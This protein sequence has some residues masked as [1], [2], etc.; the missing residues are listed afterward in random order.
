MIF[1]SKI[2]RN[3]LV[4]IPKEAYTSASKGTVFLISNVVY[5]PETRSCTSDKRVIGKAVSKLQM[6]PNSYYREHYPEEFNKYSPDHEQNITPYISYGLYAATLGIVVRNGLYPVM[7]E[8]FGPE[9]S[10]AM[11]DYA[12]YSILTQSNVTRDFQITMKQ[13]M[14]FSEKPHDDTWY[15]Q[16]FKT[17]VTDSQIELFRRKWAQKCI[18]CGLTD[19]WIAADGSNDTCDSESNILAENGHAKPGNKGDLVGFTWIV[20]AADGT[21]VTWDVYRGGRVDCKEISAMV[22]FLKWYS[23]TSKGIILDRGFCNESSLNYLCSNGLNYVVMLR[24]RI[25]GYTNTLEKNRELI[26]NNVAY[27]LDKQG[28]YGYTELAERKLFNSRNSPKGYV[29]LFYDDTNGS[30][31]RTSL[32]WNVK[33]AVKEAN[34]KQQK[35]SAQQESEA[36]NQEKAD[37]SGVQM[38]TKYESYILRIQKDG[39]LCFDLNKDELQ[40]EVNKKGFSAIASSIRMDANE[41]DRIYQLRQSCEREFS[42]LKSQLGNDVMHVSGTESWKAKFCLAFI[43]GIIRN[44]LEKVCSQVGLDTN[45]MIR[46]L[47]LLTM[48]VNN[49]QKYEMFHNENTRQIKLLEKLDVDKSMLEGFAED[50]NRRNSNPIVHPVRSLPATKAVKPGRGRRKGSKN[51]KTLKR[52]DQERHDPHPSMKRG[53]G[54]P[55]GAKNK[56]KIIGNEQSEVKRGRGR[57]KGSRNKPK[58]QPGN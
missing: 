16:L 53:P 57:P 32:V 6:Y 55:K 17:N 54:R 22:G 10:N 28:Y 37:D 20:N 51:L 23:L 44:E 27:A 26:R 46:E 18:E 9:K 56:P 42:H 4:P 34:E 29:S 58:N 41:V 7:V 24:N 25:L 2:Y 40:N 50:L 35:A 15:S 30:Q 39:Q 8:C 13:Q 38:N 45:H 31:T 11:L 3:V 14:L 36:E 43:A 21:P 12:M 49:Q 1:L 19:C 33:R 5:H 47:C 52:E 48:I